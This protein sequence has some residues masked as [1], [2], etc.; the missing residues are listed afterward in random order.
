MAVI[1]DHAHRLVI[2]AERI[3]GTI[4]NERIDFHRRRR[5]PRDRT[6]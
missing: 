6:F 3:E 1:T 4:N 2:D 5:V